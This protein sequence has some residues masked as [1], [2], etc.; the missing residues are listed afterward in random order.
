[1]AHHMRSIEPW[2]PPWDLNQSVKDTL[3]SALTSRMPPSG[4]KSALTTGEVP[5][6]KEFCTCRK[7]H[8]T[9]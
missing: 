5:S 2:L 8:N 1:M 6:A 3:S 4:S 9:L 7:T